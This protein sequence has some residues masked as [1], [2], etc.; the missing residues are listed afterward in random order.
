MIRLFQGQTSRERDTART[1]R[2]GS[3]RPRLLFPLFITWTPGIG[4]ARNHR[5]RELY[6]SRVNCGNEKRARGSEFIDAILL[7][8]IA[9]SILESL[10]ESK[11]SAAIA[12][13]TVK[14]DDGSQRDIIYYG[15]DI[16][17][18]YKE[19]IENIDISS[20]YFPGERH[21]KIVINYCIKLKE[22]DTLLFINFRTQITKIQ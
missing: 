8:R 3:K 13:L 10:C 5:P 21:N 9:T 11:R 1:V 12:V 16:Q 15:D 14:F 19:E 20:I 4:R 6:E 7:D 2:I 17:K 22:K 18:K